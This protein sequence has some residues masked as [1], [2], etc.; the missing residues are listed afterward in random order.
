MFLS[1]HGDGF[2]ADY[3]VPLV[4]ESFSANAGCVL[5]QSRRQVLA[6]TIK[7]HFP[8]DSCQVLAK[9]ANPTLFMNCSGTAHAL[10]IIQQRRGLAGRPE[11]KTTERRMRGK[12][13]NDKLKLKERSRGLLFIIVY[14]TSFI[15]C[16]LIIHNLADSH[17]CSLV[18]WVLLVDCP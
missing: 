1:S 3:E 18:H 7:Y 14:Y 4:H 9:K 12:Q 13:R 16:S 15:I 11:R 2:G 10:F 6:Q 8:K 5:F 17:G